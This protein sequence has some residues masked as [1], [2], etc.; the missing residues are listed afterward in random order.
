MAS[1]RRFVFGVRVVGEHLADADIRCMQHRLADREA[2]VDRQPRHAGGA[3]QPPVAGEETLIRLDQ[4][5]RRDQFCD[6][7]ADDLQRFG[8]LVR[9]GPLV[10]V[11]DDQHAPDAAAANDRHAQQ[12]RKNLFAGF[13]PVAEIRMLLSVRQVQ[14][15]GRQRDG[16]DQAF[17]YLQPGDVHGFG[18][19]ALRREKLENVRRRGAHRPSTPPPPFPQR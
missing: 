13:R 16:A 11:L 15:L 10:A 6:H 9:I 1:R 14:R 18:V 2:F 3:E 4:V 8:F 19:Q 12:R 7:G 5:P 17:A